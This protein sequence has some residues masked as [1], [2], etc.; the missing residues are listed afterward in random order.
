M[1]DLIANED[2]AR[3]L[4]LALLGILVGTYFMSTRRGEISRT[5][6]QALAWVGIFAIFIMAF[7][8]RDTLM[9]GLFP[10]NA[11]QIDESTIA[12]NRSTS[13]GFEAIL[14]VN[15]I[16]VKF[17][18]DTGATQI[19]LSMRDAERVGLN[20]GNL[21]FATVATTANGQ[22]KTAAVDLETISFGSLQD[23]N[24]SAVVN[25]GLL[26]VSLLGMDYLDRFAWIEIRGDRML[27][28]RP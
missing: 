3:L 10:S 22:V 4:Y 8:S 21:D 28:V 26:D 15:G 20:P 11:R 5:I 23:E 24:V 25:S 7:G 1:M 9:A 14:D 19:V 27:L 17:L 12:L 16:P 18:V 6:Q 13:G 2:A